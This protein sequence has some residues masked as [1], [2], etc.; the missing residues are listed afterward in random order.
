MY[1]LIFEQQVYKDL[2]RIPAKDLDRI[3]EGFESLKRD[4]R[5]PGAKKLQNSSDR[6]RLRKGNY[7]IIY[8]IDDKKTTVRIMIVRH[9]KDVYRDR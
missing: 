8:I 3:S 9:R 2:D 1:T 6:Y 7:R 5:M 4:P